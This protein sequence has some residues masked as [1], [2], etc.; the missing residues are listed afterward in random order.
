MRSKIIVFF[1]LIFSVSALFG[2]DIGDL[3]YK[4]RNGGVIITNCL[5]TTAGELS[6]PPTIEDKP[7]TMIGENAF[8]SCTKLTAVVIPDTV[9]RIE[10]K[11]FYG[12]VGLAS[13]TVPDSVTSIG[14]Y[15]FGIKNKHKLLKLESY[16]S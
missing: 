12:C 5:S 14:K 8:R 9:T 6:I 4:V 11:A 15:A 13:L 2:A 10:D 16:E 1:A 3:S 7:V